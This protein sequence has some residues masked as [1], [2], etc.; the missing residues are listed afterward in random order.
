MTE[1]TSPTN[2]ESADRRLERI[3][4]E[5]AYE[6]SRAEAERYRLA[7]ISHDCNDSEKKFLIVSASISGQLDRGTGFWIGLVQEAKVISD[8]GSPSNKGSVLRDDYFWKWAKGAMVGEYKIDGER[9]Y[10]RIT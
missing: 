7:M 2:I 5:A 8:G 10:V 1:R 4:L 9:V 3:K 6:A